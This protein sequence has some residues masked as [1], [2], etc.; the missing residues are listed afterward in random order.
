[1][2]M[3]GEEL[4]PLP[5]LTARDRFFTIQNFEQLALAQKKQSCPEPSHRVEIIFIFQD[6]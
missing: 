2:I 1:M 4:P 3:A 6:F 5:H